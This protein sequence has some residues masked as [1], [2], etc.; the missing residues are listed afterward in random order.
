MK[1]RLNSRTVRVNCRYS[2][3]CEARWLLKS[4]HMSIRLGYGKPITHAA[5]RAQII[6]NYGW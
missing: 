2:A 1:L 6:A 3:A 4:R 5:I